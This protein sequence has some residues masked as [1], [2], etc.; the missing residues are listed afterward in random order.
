MKEDKSE[1]LTSYMASKTVYLEKGAGGIQIDFC[2]PTSSI[3]VEISTGNLSKAVNI[4]RN[5]LYEQHGYELLT[6]QSAPKDK[7]SILST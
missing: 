6:Y 1:A 7:V 2:I 3:S 5:A 4:C